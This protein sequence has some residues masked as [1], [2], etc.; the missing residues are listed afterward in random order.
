M[1]AKGRIVDN[2][3]LKSV[4]TKLVSHDPTNNNSLV[5]H[6]LWPAQEDVV[7][8]MSV[9]VLGYPEVVGQFPVKS[10]SVTMLNADMIVY[11][12]LGYNEVADQFVADGV[13][14]DT[15]IRDSSQEAAMDWTVSDPTLA[16]AAGLGLFDV[17]ID[18]R[19]Y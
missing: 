18:A 10:N 19:S 16:E 17:G 13:L 2:V 8:K 14:S 6:P 4:P 1:H 9:L 11:P 12:P 3:V 7:E 15:N 5:D